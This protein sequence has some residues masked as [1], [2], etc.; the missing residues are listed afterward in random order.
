MCN[1]GP[2]AQTSAIYPPTLNY[3]FR[4]IDSFSQ[5]VQAGCTK[6]FQH[7]RQEMISNP[8]SFAPH[9]RF[10]ELFELACG[11]PDQDKVGTLFEEILCLLDSH[12]TQPGRTNPDRN[13]HSPATS[14]ALLNG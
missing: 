8:A 10:T 3:N 6:T 1:R 4:G 9:D 7:S 13:P 5:D 14:A 11:E 2:L 12:T